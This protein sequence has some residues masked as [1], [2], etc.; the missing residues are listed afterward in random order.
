MTCSGCSVISLVHF[1]DLDHD[2]RGTPASRETHRLQLP[3]AMQ[4][5]QVE[6]TDAVSPEVA[7]MCTGRRVGPTRP[8]GGT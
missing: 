7:T 6:L 3:T 1:S 5:D 2:R 4:G 8:A